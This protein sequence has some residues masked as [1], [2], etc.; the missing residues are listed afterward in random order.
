MA[1]DTTPD[2]GATP[3]GFEAVEGGPELSTGESPQVVQPE[4]LERTH[5]TVKATFDRFPD[6]VLRHEINAGDQHVLFLESSRNLELLGWLRDDPDQKFDLLSDVTAVD[7]GGGR[8][9]QVVYQL[10]SI[11]YRRSLRVKC[12]LPLDALEIDSVVGLWSTA[13]WLEREVYDMFGI[14][15]RNHPDLR[16]ILMPKNYAEGHPLRKDFPLRGRF[17]RAEQTRRALDL[18]AD[19]YYLPGERGPGRD[20]QILGES[21]E[22]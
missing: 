4:G 6:A 14:T 8:P 20:P 21:E 17:S 5:P 10:W 7:Y 2:E 13:N 22:S 18:D 3:T 15:F 11:T 1:D 12:E 9:L 19:D 16:R